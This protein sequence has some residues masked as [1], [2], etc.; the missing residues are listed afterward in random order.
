MI[1]QVFTCLSLMIN[2]IEYL[3]MNQLTIC[4]TSLEKCLFKSFTQFIIC[5]FF[6]FFFFFLL[7]SCMTSSRTLDV[8]LLWHIWF[9]DIFS[10]SAG[11]LFTLLACFLA[12]KN[13]LFWCGSNCLFFYFISYNS[14]V[15]S[16]NLL[17]RPMSKRFSFFFFP[18]RNFMVPC[19]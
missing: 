14:G 10:P 7:L 2:A 15:I 12:V 9:S 19:L 4:I 18:P 13:F 3:F 5:L 6:F 1:T 17:T 8:N 11:Y 16:P